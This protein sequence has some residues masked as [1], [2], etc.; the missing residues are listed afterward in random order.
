MRTSTLQARRT[1]SW[2]AGDQPIANLAAM[3][4]PENDPRARA[5]GV[6]D[7]VTTAVQH[8][9]PPLVPA[10]AKTFRLLYV[11]SASGA[12]LGTSELA[13]QLGLGKSTVH[14]LVTTLEALGIIESVDGSRRFRLGRGLHA[15]T[16]RRFLEPEM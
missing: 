8:G 13:R 15:L 11:L 1:A 10:V 14:G 12:P 2:Q 6:A 7:G 5:D 3:F 4:S 16:E 9:G